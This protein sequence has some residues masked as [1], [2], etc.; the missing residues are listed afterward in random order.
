M[1]PGQLQRHYENLAEL[2][3][4]GSTLPEALRRLEVGLDQTGRSKLEA[5]RIRD[6]LENLG[7]PGRDAWLIEFGQEQGGLEEILREL[8]QTYR[9]VQ[10]LM[11]SI[12]GPVMYYGFVLVVASLILGV[13]M[14]VL[15]GLVW[16]ITYGGGLLGTAVALGLKLRADLQARLVGRSGSLVAELLAKVPAFSQVDWNLKLALLYGNWHLMH[17]SGVNLSRSFKVLAESNNYL[18]G[19]REVSVLLDRG[20][21]LQELNIDLVEPIPAEDWEQIQ[22]GQDSGKLTETL[23]RLRDKRFREVESWMDVLPRILSVVFL[24]VVGAIVAYVLVQLYTGMYAEVF[25]AIE[26]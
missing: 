17:R 13:G 20:K 23:K 16:G 2:V 18:K 6:V 22:V 14:S 12:R 5:G 11:A 25:D 26:R 21:S 3:Q 10:D 7:F 4:A 15:D 1:G 9:R 8:S 19:F 24:I